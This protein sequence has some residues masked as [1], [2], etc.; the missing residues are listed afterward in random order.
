MKKMNNIHVII[1]NR[2][3]GKSYYERKRII[4]KNKK[5]LIKRIKETVFKECRENNF[6]IYE[7]DLIIKVLTIVEKEIWD[8]E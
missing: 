5:H 4:D 2:G 3:Y 7:N 1:S 6:S 8:Y